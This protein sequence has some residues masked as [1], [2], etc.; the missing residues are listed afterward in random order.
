LLSA[1]DMALYIQKIHDGARQPQSQSDGS[2][3]IFTPEEVKVA[4]GGDAIVTTGIYV[5]PPP[6]HTIHAMSGP[7]AFSR[8]IELSSFCSINYPNPHYVHANPKPVELSVK[9]YNRGK[10]ELVLRP[11]DAVGRI[12]VVPM[13]AFEVL[14]TDVQ[15]ILNKPPKVPGRTERR[16]NA[17][18]TAVEWF[19]RNYQQEHDYIK[20][21]FLNE[22]ILKAIE[23]YKQTPNYK[24]NANK[25]NAEAAWAWSLLDEN[26]KERIR[27]EMVL[28]NEQEERV[29][30]MAGTKIDVEAEN[31]KAERAAKKANKPS[32]DDIPDEEDAPETE[33]SDDHEVHEKAEGDPDD[34]PEGKREPVDDEE[35]EEEEDEVEDE[36]EEPGDEEDAEETF[37]PAP[38]KPAAKGAANKKPAAKTD[39]DEPSDEEP[40]APEPAPVKAAAKPAGRRVKA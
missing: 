12:F 39:E 15:E 3:S 16:I 26:V 14:E 2:Y 38:A 33:N 40:V 34:V 36:V 24:T 37:K 31:D 8:N 27:K 32:Q 5:V 17:P 28:R 30:Q 1:N 29:A 10:I 7:E 21:A 20:G 23:E 6:G 22:K 4:A 18:R 19:K 35:L 11:G 13:F 9:V 25:P